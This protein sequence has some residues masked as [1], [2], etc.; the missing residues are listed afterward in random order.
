MDKNEA[1]EILAGVISELRTRSREDLRALLGSPYTQ[2][3][4]GPSETTYQVEVQAFWDD[5]SERN[6]RVLG[7]IDDGGFSA[8]KPLTD[9]FIV[10]PDG[11]FVGE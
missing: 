2:E 1:R 9:D 11:S 10:A 8:F 6:L 7:S 3:I 4:A 5:K